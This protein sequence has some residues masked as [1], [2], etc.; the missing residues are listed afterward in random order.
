M[1]PMPPMSGATT[2]QAQPEHGPYT[3]IDAIKMC[4]TKYVTFKGR[5]RRSEYWYWILF[6]TLVSAVTGGSNFVSGVTAAAAGSD[7]FNAAGGTLSSVLS[8]V[9]FLPGLAVTF[10][11]LHDVNRSGAW[12]IAPFISFAIALGLFVA[13][14]V[15]TFGSMNDTG[16][17]SSAA[18]GLW[19]A[20][21]AFG[22]AGFALYI[23]IIVWL[24]KDGG[25]NTPNKYGVRD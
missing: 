12:L 13:A 10:R 2:S 9:F 25:P 4:F 24:C 21:L 15:T 5:A 1:P 11:R 19:I 6:T 22:I 8:L 20:M 14:L 18:T 23:P 3:F 7:S 17:L 16:D